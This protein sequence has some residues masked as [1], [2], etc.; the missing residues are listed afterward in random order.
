MMPT[1]QAPS[2]VQ[3]QAPSMPTPPANMQVGETAK[4]P[5]H[6]NVHYIAHAPHTPRGDRL[7][8]S[9]RQQPPVMMHP[10]PCSPAAAASPP[11][12]HQQLKAPRRSIAVSPQTAPT[13]DFLQRSA[14]PSKL[15][16]M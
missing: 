16:Q 12:Q 8:P 13:Q 15:Q 5:S 14:P 10:A 3:A 9:Q 11:A 7:S 4:E 2:T 1:T 6:G